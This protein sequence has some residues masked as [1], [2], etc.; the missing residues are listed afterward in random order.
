MSLSKTEQLDALRAK[1]PF[2]GMTIEEDGRK[3]VYPS[4]NQLMQEIRLLENE[5]ARSGTSN[6]L[7]IIPCKSVRRF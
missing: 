3:V 4:L 1:I 2:A 6:R 5:V 7:G